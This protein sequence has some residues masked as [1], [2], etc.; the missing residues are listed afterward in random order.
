[1]RRLEWRRFT[2]QVAAG[3]VNFLP[4]RRAPQCIASTV[5]TE[6]H[7]YFPQEDCF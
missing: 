1:M 7:E 2:G 6:A 3:P 5:S 4:P